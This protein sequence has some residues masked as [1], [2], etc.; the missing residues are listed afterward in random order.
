MLEEFPPSVCMPV[1]VTTRRWSGSTP[2]KVPLALELLLELVVCCTYTHTD[3]HQQHT[4]LFS[5][6]M[7]AICTR[8]QALVCKK[9][10]ATWRLLQCRECKVLWPHVDNLAA[11][12][13]KHRTSLAGQSDVLTCPCTQELFCSCNSQWTA[14]LEASKHTSRCL[15]R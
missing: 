10:G 6:E 2:G 14:Q 3:A 11:L 12:M 4:Q 8:V 5:T 15:C 1:L 7:R 13:Y 9:A